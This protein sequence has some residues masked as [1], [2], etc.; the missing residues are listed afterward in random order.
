MV[1][2]VKSQ[3]KKSREILIVKTILQRKEGKRRKE[4]GR[5]KNGKG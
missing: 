3:I 1:K 5:G 2:G 4:K